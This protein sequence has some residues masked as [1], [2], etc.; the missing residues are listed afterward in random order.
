MINMMLRLTGA[1]GMGLNRSVLNAQDETLL[2]LGY[3]GSSVA[4]IQADVLPVDN[5]RLL[6]IVNQSTEH[7]LLITFED[8]RAR[9]QIMPGM[10]NV[11]TPAEDCGDI[12]IASPEGPA[13][14][15]VFV[16]T[17]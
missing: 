4:S 13:Q 17:H 2:P 6:V 9:L 7:S 11:L 8:N 14:Y 3:I 15:D 12:L 1:T 5:P 16:G 10:F